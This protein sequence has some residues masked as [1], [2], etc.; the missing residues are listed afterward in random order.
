MKLNLKALSNKKFKFTWKEFVHKTLIEV[1]IP[2]LSQLE[3]SSWA[4]WGSMYTFKI[5]KTEPIFIRYNSE[6][7]ESSQ[8]K[9]HVHSPILSSER[10]SYPY[11]LKIEDDIRGLIFHLFL[12]SDYK[13]GKVEITRDEESFKQ[14]EVEAEPLE[15][16]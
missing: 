2:D 13:L 15:M 4:D 14:F 3:Y 10:E 7:I 16:V 5:D 12:K 1:H 11:F 9:L 6:L 8:K